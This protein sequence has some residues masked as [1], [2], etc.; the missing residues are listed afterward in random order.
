M[1]ISNKTQHVS[2]KVNCLKINKHN[3]TSYDDSK[4]LNLPFL[5]EFIKVLSIQTH[6]ITR[7]CMS[8]FAVVIRKQSV[9]M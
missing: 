4:I 7:L 5:L 2:H 8:L 9:T 1:I 3:F 6:Q